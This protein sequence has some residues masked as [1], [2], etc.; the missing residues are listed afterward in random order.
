MYIPK[1][2]FKES[3]QWH[4]A[5]LNTI[6]IS[7]DS[8]ILFFS[9]FRDFRENNAPY[10]YVDKLH[11]YF[12]VFSLSSTKNQLFYSSQSNTT[13]PLLCII[14]PP[15]NKDNCQIC[16]S[17]WKGFSRMLQ[18]DNCIVFLLY[19]ALLQVGDS[20]TSRFCCKLFVDNF[21][22]G[23]KFPLTATQRVFCL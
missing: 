2:F 6:L 20:S 9:F 21:T 18:L 12:R 3:A 15:R 1:S 4:K 19:L 13:S 8:R 22:G 16:T 14:V 7:T 23:A 17:R 11:L 10:I 5:A